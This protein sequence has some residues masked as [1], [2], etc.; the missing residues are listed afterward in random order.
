MWT[1]GPITVSSPNETSKQCRGSRRPA[2]RRGLC[3]AALCTV[4]LA[5]VGVVSSFAIARAYGVHAMGQYTLAIA[6]GLALTYLSTT[7]E[8]TALVRM[9]SVL[10]VR[11]PRIAALSY[12]TFSF[13]FVLTVTVGLITVGG[14]YLAFNGPVGHPGLFALAATD[15]T[16]QVLIVNSCWNLDS[17][18]IA[19]RAG[20]ELL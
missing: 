13:S 14:T 17:V 4:A 8:Q 18:F 6:P 19:F 2:I 5:S 11:S 7:Q 10:P 9:L 15:T 20:R 1:R 12:A 3:C 16:V